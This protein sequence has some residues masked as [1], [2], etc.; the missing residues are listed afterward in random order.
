MSWLPLRDSEVDR[1]RALGVIRALS[2][3]D[4]KAARAAHDAFVKP[5]EQL[6]DG[7]LI[8]TARSSDRREVS[9]RI[10]WNDEFAG[11]LIIGGSGAGKSFFLT[12]L[13]RQSI[14]AD[15]GIGC[16]D[17]KSD[18]YTASLNSLAAIAHTWSVDRRQRL[19]DRLVVVNPFS[20][21]L[22]P[23]NVCRPIPGWNPEAQA[24][25]IALTLSRLFDVAL[26]VH[27][28]NI[29]RHL[30]LLLAE[31][32]LSLVEAPLVL[33]DEILRSV[34]VKRSNNPLLKSFFLNTY[35][36]VPQV[37]K[38]A[39]L[40]RLQGL[41]LA[42][43]LRL[44]L[45]ADEVVDLRGILDRGDPMF[46]LFGKGCGMPE[47]QVEVLGGLFLQLLLQAAYARGSGTKKRYV[48]ALDEFFHIL[49]APA[50]TKRFETAL[51]TLRSYGVS[52]ILAMHNFVQL[53][54]TLREIILGNCDLTAVFKTSSR[55]ARFFGDFL[56]TMQ[57]EDL[58]QLRTG[59]SR[60]AKAQQ[61][62]TLQRLPQRTCFWYDR[63]QPYRAIHLRV[64][65]IQPAHELA[66][67]SESEL[68]ELTEQEGWARGAAAL[69]RE[70]IK[71][72]IA[73]REMRLRE[74]V[75]PRIH[76]VTPM[77]KQVV[78]AP[79]HPIGKPRL[80]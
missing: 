18:L 44:M 45:G 14:Q 56:P 69:P 34:L 58:N 67:I 46:A 2:E 3:R 9:I 64:P 13:L 35:E 25:E 8:G 79:P 51:T 24:Y 6:S 38:D 26:S 22:I 60:M 59:S 71:K 80:G 15:R 41:F 31:A 72:Q 27:M 52:L 21:Y 20:E 49:S 43:N 5:N 11:F 62:E 77:T 28:E 66:G 53:S 78:D 19:R 48:L 65:D 17:F 12:S 7:L 61:L 30:I 36:S 40:S 23:M 39:L 32:N 10:P 73:T 33:Q 70:E 29:L 54:P 1:R 75:S 37:S 42:E 50:M 68:T 47:E 4:L 76:L 63:R 55:N 57:L 74:L 16:I